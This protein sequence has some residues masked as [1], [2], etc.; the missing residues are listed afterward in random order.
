MSIECYFVAKGGVGKTESIWHK[1]ENA[2]T[3]EKFLVIDCDPRMHLTRKLIGDRN[4]RKCLKDKTSNIRGLLSQFDPNIGYVNYIRNLPSVGVQV[5]RNVRLITGHIN[6]Q[7]FELDMRADLQQT[8]NDML[9]SQVCM[10]LRT[11]CKEM[12]RGGNFNR[13]L[14]DTDGSLSL[15]NAMLVVNADS[16]VMDDLRMSIDHSTRY[17]TQTCIESWKTKYASRR[18]VNDQ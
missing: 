3:H 1:F 12:C 4:T 16:V 2:E 10:R 18:I 6:L 11:F 5:S 13:V 17:F 8:H 15:L 9:A 14:I 7:E